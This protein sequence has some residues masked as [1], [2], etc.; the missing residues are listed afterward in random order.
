MT[1]TDQPPA[2]EARPVAI[3]HQPPDGPARATALTDPAR[4]LP[5]AALARL[6]AHRILG[7][8]DA[9]IMIDHV[10]T[11]PPDTPVLA[12]G[13]RPL[14]VDEEE[15]EAGEQIPQV[16]DPATGT[17]RVLSRRCASCIYRRA[18]RATLGTSVPALIRESR[19]TGGFVICHESLPAWQG[20]D[21]S[22]PPAI[23]HGYAA[24][25]P[26]T[27]ALRVARAIGH[28]ELI[29]PPPAAPHIAHETEHRA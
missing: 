18:M 10:V 19:D 1:G 9:P 12:D 4:A 23:C 27:F 11:L 16:A 29:E 13:Q 21:P 26:D 7:E 28:I 22:I 17:V 20:E 24:Q 6:I 3:W 8:P 2:P 5:P 25:F 14:D 15:P